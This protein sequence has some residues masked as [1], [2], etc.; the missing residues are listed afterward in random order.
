MLGFLEGRGSRRRDRA[1]N[2]VVVSSPPAKWPACLG[3]GLGPPAGAHGGFRRTERSEGMMKQLSAPLLQSPP[4]SVEVAGNLPDE[5][6]VILGCNFRS[7]E[8]RREPR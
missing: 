3:F 7:K 2:A 8:I 1:C 5:E 6:P 4:L